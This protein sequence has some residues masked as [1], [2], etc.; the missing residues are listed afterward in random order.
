MESIKDSPNE[1]QGFNAFRVQKNWVQ[2]LYCSF[3][4]A[5]GVHQLW[6]SRSFRVAGKGFNT[7]F[8]GAGIPF[9]WKPSYR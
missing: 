8:T 9:P 2:P 7:P 3:V 4:S 5:S 6:Y 1:Q